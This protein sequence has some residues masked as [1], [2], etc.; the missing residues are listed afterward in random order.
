[1]TAPLSILTELLVDGVWQDISADVYNRDEV[2]ITRGRSDEGSAVDPGSCKLTL[3]NGTSKVSGV[4]GRYSPRNPRSDLYGKFGRNTGL[5]VSVL[6][7]ST[8]LDNSQG[9]V[10]GASTPDVAALDIVGDIDLRWEGE[11]DWYADGA[12]MLMGKWGVAGQRSYAMRLENKRLYMHITTDGTAGPAHFW[13]LPD[14]LPKRVAFRATMDVDNG[15]GQV[16]GRFYWGPSIAGPWTQFDDDTS[17]S[18]GVAVI[19]SGT[20]ALTISPEQIALATVPRMAFRGRTYAAE[21]RAGIDGTLVASPNFEAQASGTTSFTDSAGRAWA[22]SGTA[23]VTNRRVRFVG[24]VTEWPTTWELAASDGS[25]GYVPLV[26]SGILRRLGQG[27][28]SLESPLRRRI[29]SYKPLGYWPMEEGK[30]ATNARSL[31]RYPFPL[32]LSPAEWAADSSLASSA[33]LPTIKGGTRM[34]AL[35]LWPLKT[36]TSWHVQFVYK[37]DTMQTAV[38]T[39]MHIASTGTVA[40]WFLQWGQGVA[41]VVG[42]DAEGT[43]LFTDQTAI[44]SDLW[45]QWIRVQFEVTQ[46]GNNFDYQLIWTD[47]GGDAGAG[48]GT[49]AGKI[50]RPSSLGSP[51][52]GFSA[53]LDGMSIGHVSVWDAWT[54]QSIASY[55]RAIDA[56]AGE[57]AGARMQRLAAEESLPLIMANGSNGYAQVGTQAQDTVLAVLQDA[58]DAD[59]GVLYEQRNQVGLYYRSRA[60]FYNQPAALAL[61]FNARGLVTPVEPV[62]DDQ[63]LRNDRTIERRDGGS[64]RAVLEAG[65]LSVQEPPLGVGTYDDSTTLNLFSDEQADA[66]A[67]WYLHR[68]TF[69]EAR[70]PSIAVDLF[71]APELASDAADL[72]VGDR[73]TVAN[74]PAWL[75]PGLIDQRVEGY[76]ESISLTS[77]RIAYNCT[78]QGAYNVA[79]VDGRS[80][81]MGNFQAPMKLDTDGSALLKSLTTTGTT[82]DVAVTAGPNWIQAPP[83][84]SP[85]PWLADD[86]SGWHGSVGTVARVLAPNPPTPSIWALRLTPNS[87]ASNPNAYTDQQPATPGLQ[88]KVSG[89]V[90]S[91]TTHSVGVNLNWYTNG[92]YTSTSSNTATLQPNVWTWFEKTFT[93]PAG[94]NGAS[95]AAT[96]GG[97]ATPADTLL[98]QGATIRPVQGP[99]NSRDFPFSVTIA[100]EEVQ[101]TGVQDYADTF[102][103]TTSSTW[104][105]SEYGD[106]WTAAGGSAAEFSV[107]PGAAK[108]SLTSINTSRYVTIPAPSADVDVTTTVATS[109]L[110]I[111]GA[112]LVGPV[113][114]YIDGNNMYF[115]RLALNTNQTL[116]LLLQKRV[117]GAQTDLPSVTVPGTHVAGAQYK[118]RFLVEGST[119]SAKAWPATSPEP[120]SWQVSTTD[121]DLSAAGSVGTRSILSG[122]NTNTLPIT[123]TYSAFKVDHF[124]R[125]RLVRALNGVAKPHSVGEPVSLTH[126]AIV[127]L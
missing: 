9:Q 2:T 103:R 113:A 12:Q 45:G 51:S 11:G 115:A 57:T 127:A 71:A 80:E 62:D 20:S 3:N 87:G 7:G 64:A 77:W 1:M 116:T 53:D 86:A 18:T 15:A 59:G 91:A 82:A 83:A 31:G 96:V 8:F 104:G 23:A 36:L 43:T 117:A 78:P 37:H 38:R 114:R 97:S 85:N 107:A 125:F 10:D 102:Q 25:D 76:E 110:A 52:G 55:D 65:P 14:N 13:A 39:Y 32:R 70:Y 61:D 100:G 84:L 47:V 123:V 4:L 95:I 98:I 105:T 68:G 79:Q 42:R 93:A 21:V 69:D 60:S 63:F 30:D 56:W 17:K 33:A 26:A 106:A 29:P 49:H 48:S 92:T 94:I 111:G 126:P 40:E 27:K 124:Q 44:G 58:A 72:D 16:Q 73:L 75:P 121:T 28:K 109:A 99:V 54:S 46:N 119:L 90:R 74:P 89:W 108:V 66:T 122:T 22:V 120:G 88:Y 112:H 35:V 5:R 34:H 50:G 118:V 81:G 101:V 67:W 6:E 19:F 41:Q 24:E